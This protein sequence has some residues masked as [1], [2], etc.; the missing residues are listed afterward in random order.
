[1]L[2]RP[3]WLIVLVTTSALVYGHD[4]E[5]AGGCQCAKACEEPAA[6][7]PCPPP[8]PCN[9]LFSARSLKVEKTKPTWIETSPPPSPRT[10]E[11]V[12]VRPSQK[13][14]I[15]LQKKKAP[16]QR[17]DSEEEEEQPVAVDR[18]GRKH[19]HDS[20]LLMGGAAQQAQDGQ[21]Q[22]SPARPKD[23][24]FE[25]S[26]V[27][28]LRFDR[29][30]E[31]RFQ[32]AKPSSTTTDTTTIGE[33]EDDEHLDDPKCNSKTLRSIM[34]KQMNDNSAQSKRRVNEASEAKFGTRIDVICSRGHFSYVY[35]SNLFCET[36]KGL[37]TCIA[38]RQ[39]LS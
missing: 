12:K 38:F 36:T 13:K 7:E 34:E 4:S 21:Q 30:R 9:N 10:Y 33:V 19:S 39:S 3:T 29:N 22:R 18:K 8:P 6:C 27:R 31:I 25:K 24:D 26:V 20:R 14:N 5:E 35:S 23:Q 1:M 11:M 17:I 16:I 32:Q 28:K 15:A 2:L 37:V